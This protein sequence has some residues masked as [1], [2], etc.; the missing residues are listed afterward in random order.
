MY[1]VF[2][3]DQAKLLLA[4]RAQVCL[5][6]HCL[7][8]FP[9]GLCGLKIL[10]LGKDLLGKTQLGLF[11]QVVLVEVVEFGTLLEVAQLPHQRIL[12]IFWRG[13]RRPAG[14][15]GQRLSVGPKWR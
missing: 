1:C 6:L 15:R 4:L 11:D 12:V 9:V 14:A 2:Q 13:Q 8:A 10:F 3:V 5:A 7:F